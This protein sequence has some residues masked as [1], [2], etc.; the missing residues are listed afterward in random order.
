MTL[1]PDGTLLATFS[2]VGFIKLWDVTNEFKMVRRLRDSRETNIE[3]FY[4]G[5]FV[6][7]QELLVAGGKLKDRFRWSA[8]DEDNHIMPCPVK[9]CRYNMKKS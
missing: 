4:C 1:S 6:D 9:V 2:S 5:Q 7:S 8:Q 3:E